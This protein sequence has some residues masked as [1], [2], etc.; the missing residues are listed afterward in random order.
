MSLVRREGVV[1][2]ACIHELDFVELRSALSGWGP[3][4]QK[5]P[6]PVGTRGAVVSAPLGG[7]WVSVEVVAS[8]GQPVC[9]FDVRTSD[10]R[11]IAAH[12]PAAA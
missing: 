7:Q 12:V 11:V 1:A 6:V 5:V 2:M 4:G 8:G 3:D 10:L 9:F